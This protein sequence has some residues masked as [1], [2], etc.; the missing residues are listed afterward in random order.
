[1]STV[2]EDYTEDA[3]AAVFRDAETVKLN[4]VYQLI[5]IAAKTFLDILDTSALKLIVILLCLF[6]VSFSCCHN[7]SK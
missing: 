3:L 1:M 4:T 2:G 6:I 5:N 7:P